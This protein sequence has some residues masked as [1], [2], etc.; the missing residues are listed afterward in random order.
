MSLSNGIPESSTSVGGGTPGYA[1]I[2]QVTS[3]SSRDL[4]VT[5]DVYVFGAT[6]FKMH[7]GIKTPEASGILNDGFPVM[8]L[9]HYKVGLN[10]TRCIEKAMVSLKKN[11]YQNIDS[12]ASNQADESTCVL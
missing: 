3:Y 9:K 8:E 10:T 1:L 6:L 11:R 4:P 2:E 12:F 5:M 7:T